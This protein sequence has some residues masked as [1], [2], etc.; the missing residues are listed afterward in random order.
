MTIIDNN[1]YYLEGHL[2]EINVLWIIENF[3]ISGSADYTIRKWDIKSNFFGICSKNEDKVYV[4]SGH[5][6]KINCLKSY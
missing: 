3:L 2:S 1:V 6:G 4:L 5:K